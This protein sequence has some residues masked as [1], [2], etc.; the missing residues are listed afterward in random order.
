[1][2]SANNIIKTQPKG[3]HGMRYLRLIDVLRLPIPRLMNPKKITLR[4][5][6]L[7]GEVSEYFRGAYFGVPAMDPDVLKLWSEY[8]Q[9]VQELH[10]YDPELFSELME[11]PYPA[12]ALAGSES[13]HREGTMVYTPEHFAPLRL[14]TEQLLKLSIPLTWNKESA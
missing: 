11:I 6:L 3:Q 9:I 7:L 1:M 13:F 8:N 14:A 5:R 2:I 12:P 10:T 4:L